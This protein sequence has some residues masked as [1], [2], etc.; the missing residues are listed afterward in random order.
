MM[1]SGGEYSVPAREAIYKK[2]HKLAYGEDW[3]Y[4]YETFVQQDL[5]TISSVS[6]SSSRYVP[7]PARV[8]QKHYYKMESSIAADGKKKTTVIMN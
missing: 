1:G 8:S 3:Q 2:I 6:Q 7:Y 5:K 4:D